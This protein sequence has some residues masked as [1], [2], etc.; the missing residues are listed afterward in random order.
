ML[1]LEV[2]GAS[3]FIYCVL[4][5]AGLWHVLNILIQDIR[6]HNCTSDCAIYTVGL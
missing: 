3:F 4:N 1:D 5:I 2:L 6:S